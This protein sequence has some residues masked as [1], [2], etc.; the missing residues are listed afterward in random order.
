MK[1]ADSY[2]NVY[3]INSLLSRVNY[4]FNDKYYLSASLRQDASSRF[5]RDSNKG[6]FWSLGG[7][8]RVSNE[9]F[10][11][12]VKWVDNLNVKVSYGEQKN[13]NIGK[14]YAWQSLYNLSYKNADNLGAVILLRSE[15]CRVGKECRSRWSPYH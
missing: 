14:L 2:T 5:H 9:A 11:K 6:T 3:R 7:N 13:D 8:W 15:E 4:N 12:D 1:V 10:M